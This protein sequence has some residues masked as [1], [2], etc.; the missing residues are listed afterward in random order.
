MEAIWLKY[1][2]PTN[3][4]VPYYS[5]EE[6]RC[7]FLNNEMSNSQGL[8]LHIFNKHLPISSIKLTLLLV[9]FGTLYFSSV[10]V[11]KENY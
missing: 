6:I 7:F 4:I 8:S 5:H 2:K 10:F 9:W 1:Y 3:F 11:S